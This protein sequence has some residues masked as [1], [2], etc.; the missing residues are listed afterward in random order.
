MVGQLS[1][2]RKYFLEKPQRRLETLTPELITLENLESFPPAGQFQHFLKNLE[3]LKN[4]PLALKVV[5]GSPRLQNPLF[6]FFKT[7]SINNPK[8]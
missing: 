8:P 5:Q 7:F 2:V 4:E 6:F 1:D 3:K